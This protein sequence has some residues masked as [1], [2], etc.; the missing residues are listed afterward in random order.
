MVWAFSL[1]GSPNDRIAQFEA[2]APPPTGVTFALART[3]R[4]TK[5]PY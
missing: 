1:K 3:E 4:R 5:T 2:P